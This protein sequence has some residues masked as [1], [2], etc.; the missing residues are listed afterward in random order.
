MVGKTIGT[1]TNQLFH[2]LA[3]SKINSTELPDP[4]AFTIKNPTVF[5]CGT[6]SANEKGD[7]NNYNAVNNDEKYANDGD[8]TWKHDDKLWG[9]LNPV[10]KA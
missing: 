6:T 7:F 9:G 3:G 8:W 4:I 5:M 1:N 2:S 10:Q